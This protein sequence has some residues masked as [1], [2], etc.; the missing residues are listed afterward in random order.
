MNVVVDTNV[1][2]SA[3]FFKNSIPDKALRRI[4]LN[5]VLLLSGDCF[6]ELL[7]TFG[8][9][10]LTKYS[11]VKDRTKFLLQLQNVAKFLNP[12]LSITACRDP[13]DNKFLELAIAGDADFIIT[14]DADLLTLN[15]FREIQI[16][17]PKNFLELL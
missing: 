13:N 7:I 1:L 14:G 9:P 3:A 11:T 17:T 15:P 6:N 10:K 16:I 4:I 5:H 2:I 12:E 8:K